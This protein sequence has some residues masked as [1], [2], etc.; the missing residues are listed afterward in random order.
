MT[1]FRKMEN[2]G[3]KIHWLKYNQLSE[4]EELIESFIKL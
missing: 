3:I 1:W 2:G 4:A